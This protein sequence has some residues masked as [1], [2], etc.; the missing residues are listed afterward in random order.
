MPTSWCAISYCCNFVNHRHLQ[1]LT[2]GTCLFQFANKEFGVFLLVRLQIARLAARDRITTEAALTEINS[3]MPLEAKLAKA[4]DVID[5]TGTV[6]STKEQV[7]RGILLLFCAD[8]IVVMGL[9][10]D[11]NSTCRRRT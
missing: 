4:D 6:E 11:P 5:N 2:H 1:K 7:G 8:C 9:S 3:Q 10:F